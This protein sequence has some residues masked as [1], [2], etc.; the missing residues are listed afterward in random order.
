MVNVLLD[1]KKL[2]FLCF[3][4]NKIKHHQIFIQ[5]NSQRHSSNDL[6]FVPYSWKNCI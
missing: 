4:K 3:M 6:Y 5:E 1:L 2:I